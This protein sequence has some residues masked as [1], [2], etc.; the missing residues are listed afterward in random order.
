[1]TSSIMTRRRH[2]EPDPYSFGARPYDLVKEFTIALVVVLGLT[3]ALAAVFSSPDEKPMTIAS[4]AKADPGDFT[5]TAL[6]ELDGSSATAGYG[7]PYNTAADGQ[8]LGPLA[9]AKFA[10]VTHPIDTAQA[11]VLG[12]LGAAP[13]D[14][15]VGA[16]LSRYNAASADQQNKWTGAYSDA[17]TKANDDPTKVANGD[18]GPVPALL[19]QLQRQAQSGSLDGALLS[20][21]GFYQTD[22]T[23]PLLFLADG[24]DLAARADTQHLSGDQW[25]MMNETG[26]FP[27]Q[28]WLWL[29]TFWYQISPYNHSDN[30]DA[31]VWG[32]M[33]VLSLA[34]VFVP[35]IP[36]ARSIPR[37][38]PVYR[39]IWREHYREQ[40]KVHRG[41]RGRSG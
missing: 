11:F 26:N 37:L 15:A 24:S 31:L 8:K 19:G 22:Y 27:G 38:V 18:Y 29:Y 5:A 6:S 20:E 13:Q 36:G 30:A 4:W 3:F 7:P 23:L 35:F 14:A 2:T 21:G 12:P 32:T 28:A 10:G 16:A 41:S 34:F 40:P 39:L 1:M 25:G 9:P 33:A 17:L